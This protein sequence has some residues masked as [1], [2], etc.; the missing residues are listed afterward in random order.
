ME[1]RIII[2]ESLDAKREK[3]KVISIPMEEKSQSLFAIE[4]PLPQRS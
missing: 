2:L 3:V 4:I 1:G